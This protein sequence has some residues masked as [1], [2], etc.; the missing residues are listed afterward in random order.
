MWIRHKDRRLGIRDS[1][2]TDMGT[3][4]E[5]QRIKLGNMM[6]GIDPGVCQQWAGTG[7]GSRGP[8]TGDRMGSKA[9]EQDTGDRYLWVG[10]RYG[11]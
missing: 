6:F 7:T 8:E 1:D 4:D 11:A 9:W 2:R 10:D 5:R 3:G